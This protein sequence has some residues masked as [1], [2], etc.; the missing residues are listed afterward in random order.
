VLAAPNETHVVGNLGWVDHGALWICD[1]ATSQVDMVELG[2]YENLV[3]QRGSEGHF[4]VWQQHQG[5][6]Y[7]V[8]VR[9]LSRPEVAL[10]EV[11]RA[12]AGVELVGD[13]HVWKHVARVYAGYEPSEGVA[14]PY[15]MLCID[16]TGTSGELHRLEWFNS[17]RYDLD[18]QAVLTPV[19]LPSSGLV[20]VP[21]QRS[22]EPVVYDPERREVVGTFGLAGRYGNPTLRFLQGD[23]WADDYDHL[24]RLDGSDWSVKATKCLQAPAAG[25]AQ[26]IGD[27]DF[28]PDGGRCVVGRPFSG[29][30]VALD[31]SSLQ[32]VERA[33]L[34]QEPLVAVLLSDGRV[35]ARDW[36]TGNLLRGK[37]RRLRWRRW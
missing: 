3:L 25:T 29:D 31:A 17:D 10:S 11:R 34:G 35:L 2:P 22:S 23:L 8:S 12:D 14:E 24:M 4:S 33:Q 15:T 19:Q 7:S 28:T 18:Y 9:L 27:W 1:T 36:K 20:I 32:V 30:V 16:P 13:P 21:V 37:A 6:G 26:F 5:G